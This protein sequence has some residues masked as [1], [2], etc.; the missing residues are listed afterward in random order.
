MTTH[1]IHPRHTPSVDA[2]QQEAGPRASPI[3]LGAALVAMVAM[4]TWWYS[5]REPGSAG[6]EAPVAAEPIPSP[7]TGSLTRDEA[8]A[9]S[10]RPGGRHATPVVADRAARPLAGN[11]LPEYPRTALRSG[12]AGGVVLSID[13]DPRGIPADV[14]VVQRDGDRSRSFDRAAIEA[15]RQWRFEPAIRGGKAVSST[16]RLPIDFQRG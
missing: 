16:V 1:T 12:Q 2:A 4:G 7:A 3:L 14:R 15:A 9:R 8:A 6:T 11:P 5:Q 13:V 10:S